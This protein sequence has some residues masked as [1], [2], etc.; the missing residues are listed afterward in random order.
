MNRTEA[1]Q[2]TP[3]AGRGH[4]V[5]RWLV[6]GCL[7]VA[8]ALAAPVGAISILKAFPA[9][10]VD[11]THPRYEIV[12]DGTGYLYGTAY[13]G[14]AMNLG[15]IFKVKN[16]G[17]NFTLLHTFTG[18]ATDGALPAAG[19]GTSRARRRAGRGSG[20]RSWHR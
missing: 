5:A 4:L 17:S 20:G 18:G 9:N 8:T 3:H 15:T 16:D 6:V 7:A 13:Q 19:R 12:A 1:A 11:G 2:R 14:G 10:P